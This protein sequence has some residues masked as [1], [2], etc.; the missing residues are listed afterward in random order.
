MDPIQNTHSINTCTIASV[1]LQ[2]GRNRCYSTC[3]LENEFCFVSDA[4]RKWET[5]SSPI[6]QKTLFVQR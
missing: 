1:K 5:N 6:S 4:G 2:K 3:S